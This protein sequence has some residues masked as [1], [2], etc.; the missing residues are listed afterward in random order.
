MMTE[1]D[2]KISKESLEWI[3]KY[4]KNPSPSGNETDGQRLW[5]E[6]ILPFVDE[7]FTD[8][9]GNAV[10]VINPAAKFKVVIEAHS[11]E[12][13]WYVHTIGKDGFLHVQK[14]GGTDPGIAPSQRVRI[15]TEQGIVRGIFGWPAVHTRPSSMTPKSDTIFVDCGCSS[16]KQVEALGIRIGDCVTYESGFS[17][18]NKHFFVGR[19]QDNKMGGFMIASIA[20]LLR[21]NDISLPYGLYIVNSVQE[22]VGLRGA[23]LVANKVKPDCAIVTDVTHATRTPLV[24]VR[25]EGDLDLQKGPVIKKSPPVHNK[26]REFIIKV[27]RDENIPHQFSVSSKKTG[28]D[29]DAFA[30]SQNGIPSA[31]VSLPLRYMHTTV[32][33]TSK[34]DIENTIKLIYHV[35]LKLTPE[36][37]FNYL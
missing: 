27:A 21:E 23:A 6:Y 14:N 9:Y 37:N 3:K 8:Y 26:L 35:L 25:K 31:L 7:H 12:I 2:F 24:S 22:E 15:R 34:R 36:F 16:K 11:D 19:G 4:L 28:T 17:T 10:A 18:L 5:L 20:R 29:T 33:T 1:T 13:A 32:E 30:Y